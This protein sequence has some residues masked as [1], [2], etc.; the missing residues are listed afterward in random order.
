MKN[1]EQM[2]NHLR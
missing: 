1:E 2:I